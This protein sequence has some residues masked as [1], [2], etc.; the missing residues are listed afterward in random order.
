MYELRQ[1][2]KNTSNVDKREIAYHIVSFS[3]NYK[4]IYNK[5]K[6]L[7]ALYDG[8]RV[9]EVIFIISYPTEKIEDYVKFLNN[10]YGNKD[11]FTIV[12]R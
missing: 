6:E 2:Y 5:F 3:Y 8:I 9:N 7:K 12:K 4:D 1:Y 11:L 10:K